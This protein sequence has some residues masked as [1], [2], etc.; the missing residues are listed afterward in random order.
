MIFSRNLH[1]QFTNV[2]LLSC[3]TEIARL[4]IFQLSSVVQRNTVDLENGLLLPLTISRLHSPRHHHCRSP[5]PVLLTAFRATEHAVMQKKLTAVSCLVSSP[6]YIGKLHPPRSQKSTDHNHNWL[7][8]SRLGHY[9]SVPEYQICTVQQRLPS[10]SSCS[11]MSS[12]RS[13]SI[14]WR[15]GTAPPIIGDEP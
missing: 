13:T 11:S 8:H 3:S 2:H 14:C 10:L 9:M 6:V 15:M 1:N 5:L 4:H 7:P 12:L